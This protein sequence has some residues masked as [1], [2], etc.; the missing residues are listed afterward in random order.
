MNN[1]ISNIPATSP[2]FPFE[3]GNA[4]F[5]N[6]ASCGLSCS[7]TKVHVPDI[8]YIERHHDKPATTI[9]LIGGSSVDTD[10]SIDEIISAGPGST[11][12]KTRWDEA[13]NL[14]HIDRIEGN[15]F[16]VGGRR[17]Y[18][19]DNA[20]VDLRSH[21]TLCKAERRYSGE[22]DSNGMSTTS[23][24][25]NSVSKSDGSVRDIYLFSG[26]SYERVRIDSIIWISAA[27]NYCDIHLV[28]KP[29][30]LCVIFLLGR[31]AA[32]LPRH[33][34]VRISRSVIVNLNFVERIQGP[35]L[36]VPGC[37]LKVPCQKV[38]D[39]PSWFS[40]PRQS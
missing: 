20:G 30:P 40:I 33:L 38:R 10:A 18:L 3:A 12:L 28:G 32:H 8:L 37:R 21:L 4:I 39:I 22:F 2:V 24:D 25:D 11:L 29:A 13:V 6:D 5:V 17:H 15:S 27:G 23:M 36:F 35:V 26:L 19:R 34:F 7:F 14:M 9:F 31:L 16:I 1:L